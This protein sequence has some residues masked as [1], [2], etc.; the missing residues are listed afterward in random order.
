MVRCKYSTVRERDMDLLFLELIA[1][2]QEFV[3]L[4]LKKLDFEGTDFKVVDVELSRTELSLG[5]SDITVKIDINGKRYGILIEDKVDAIAQPDQYRRYQ[6]RGEKGKKKGEYTDYRLFIFCPHKYLELNQEAQKYDYCLEYEEVLRYLKDKN[7]SISDIRVQQVEQA[8]QKAK[9]PASW[10]INENANMFFKQ[11]VEYMKSNYPQ[12][13]LRT[14][15]TSN[16]WWAHFGT[17]FGK[18]FIY[19]KMIE[20]CVDFTF[21]NAADKLQEMELM[22]SWLRRHGILGVSAQKTGNAGAFRIEV[23]KLNV[24]EKD[25]FEKTDEKELRTCFEAIA[26]FYEVADFLEAGKNIRNLSKH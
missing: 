12:F 9:K 8:I 21:P 10:N 23:P 5:E 20:G 22:A 25:A 6:K 7:D 15:E 3:R 19:H 24:K 26:A 16:G 2:D 1:T 17:K 14:K 18:A 13:D 4:I 11:Y